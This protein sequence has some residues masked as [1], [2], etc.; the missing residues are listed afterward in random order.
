MLNDSLNKNH[1]NDPRL[2]YNTYTGI[3]NLVQTAF[4]Y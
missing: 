4:L 1:Y 2:A 3:Q